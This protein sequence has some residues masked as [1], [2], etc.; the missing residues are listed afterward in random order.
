VVGVT[1]AA[2]NVGLSELAQT[3]RLQVA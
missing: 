1:E 2:V 3:L